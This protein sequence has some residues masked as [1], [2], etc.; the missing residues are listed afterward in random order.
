MIPHIAA[1]MLFC[2][3]GFMMLSMG[4]YGWRN[5]DTCVSVVFGMIGVAMIELGGRAT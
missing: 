1:G 4:W 5:G 2:V 3:V